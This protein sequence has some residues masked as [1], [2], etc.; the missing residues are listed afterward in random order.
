MALD[1]T[2]FFLGTAVALFI[3]LLAWGNFIRRPREDLLKLEQKYIDTLG[4][5]KKQI[6]PLIRPYSTYTF[7]QQ[8]NSILDVW[9]DKKIKGTDIKLSKEI[10]G[11]H[12]L[13]KRLENQYAFRYFGTLSLIIISFVLGIFSEILGTASQE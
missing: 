5:K 8:M 2:G 11:L 9:S 1:L 10:R 6:L 13:R 4:G 12:D 7:N 3:T